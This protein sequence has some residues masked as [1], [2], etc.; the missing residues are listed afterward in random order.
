[1]MDS[2]RKLI[3]GYDL[4]D[5]Y[6]Q[7]SC[8]SYKTFEPILVYPADNDDNPL[9][10]TALCE[11]S[12]LKAWV[13]GKEAVECARE[14]E[15]VLIDGLL[16]KLKHGEE[17]VVSGQKYSAVSLMEK[18]LRKTLTL[19]K[20]YF[21]TEPITRIVVTLCDMDPVIVEGV[22]KALS[23]LGIEKDRASIISHGSSF[24]YYALS[25]PKE[26]WLNDVGLF[27]FNQNGLNYYQISINRRANPMIAG[28]EKKD[29]SDTM[30]YSVL[31]NRNV[32]KEY[33]FE[34]IANTVLYKQIISTLYFTGRGFDGG[35]AD[36]VIKSLCTGRRVFVGQ[37]LY[38]YGACYA[39][40]ELAR[41]S[42]LDNIILINDEMTVSSIALMAYADGMTREVVLAD[43][44]M[45]WYEVNESVDVIPEDADNIELVIRNIMTKE[46]IRERLPLNNLPERPDR[47]T[48]LNISIS[49]LDKT[50]LKVAISDLGFGEYYPGTGVLAEYI[51][52]I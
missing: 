17:V 14:G 47:M 30:N 48:R 5:D 37:S 34:I 49:C 33:S 15:G 7:I 12:E 25:Q 31:S 27:D 26:L 51:L 19:I 11:K 29:F 4:C 1:M 3:V 36:N 9:I 10:P 46:V 8:Y 13:C 42:S 38:S 2:T 22:Y 41:D 43:A 16:H 50:K 52:N 24:L 18:Y 45:P 23:M 39:A 44:A 32:D 20:N 28:L 6:T 21:P 40:K 35:W